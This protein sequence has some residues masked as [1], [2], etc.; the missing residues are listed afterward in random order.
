MIDRQLWAS[1]FVSAE[2][3][4]E[5]SNWNNGA[6]ARLPAD[7]TWDGKSCDSEDQVGRNGMNRWL[8]QLLLHDHPPAS[9]QLNQPLLSGQDGKPANHIHQVEREHGRKEAP[10]RNESI[11]I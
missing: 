11:A 6:V 5:S 8:V 3:P 4:Y 9:Y 2:V 1:P 10:H 7:S